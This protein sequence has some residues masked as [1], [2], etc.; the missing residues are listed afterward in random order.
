MNLISLN[1][2]DRS[3]NWLSRAY[4]LL[5]LSLD[6]LLFFYLIVVCHRVILPSFTK[7]EVTDWSYSYSIVVAFSAFLLSIVSSKVSPT[8]GL[9][10]KGLAKTKLATTVGHHIGWFSLSVTVIAGWIITKISVIDFFSAKGIEQA[11][12]IF[13][14]L[15][16]PD[17]AI[18]DKALLAII[19][20]IYIALISTLFALPFSFLLGMLMARNV[21]GFSRFTLL[22]YFVLRFIANFTRSIEPLI[23]AIIFT[24]WVGI[25]P[26]AGMLALLVHT[27]SSLAKQ[28]SEQIEDVEVGTVEAIE[29]VG[30]NRIQVIWFAIVPQ[31]VVPFLSFTIYRWDI[32]VR[33]ATIIGLVGGGGIGNLIIQYQGLALWNEVGMC[34]A[35]V[36]FVVWILDFVSS[37]VRSALL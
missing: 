34:L 15:V 11:S 13:R 10:Q 31:L 22:V 18:A 17:L 6:F 30:A 12:H 2:T 23:W 19:D 29:A 8:R 14:A 5:A 9:V 35:L 26:F 4:A 7:S 16:S 28:Y 20:T 36:V 25:G 32:N 37:R 3:S 24:V 1:S 21:M 27:I 33:M